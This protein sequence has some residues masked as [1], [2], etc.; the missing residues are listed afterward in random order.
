MSK[1]FL[2]K[3]PS[4]NDC[5]FILFIYLPLIILSTSGAIEST[6]IFSSELER[7]IFAGIESVTM[8]SSREFA[9]LICES[10]GNTPCGANARTAIAH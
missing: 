3:Q 1:E 8:S 7:S 4:F 10:F 6:R 2:K 5:L 9:S